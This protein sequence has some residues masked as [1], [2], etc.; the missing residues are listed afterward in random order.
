MKSNVIVTGAAG[1][2]G[3]RLVQALLAR[4]TVAGPSG[5][6]VAFEELRAIDLGRPPGGEGRLATIEGDLSR[7]E[8][9]EAL[10]DAGTLCVFHLAAVVSG[11]AE[12]DFDKGMRVNLD[13]SRLLLEA[14]RHRSRVPTFVFASSVAV[15]G[16][17]LP[18]VVSERVPAAPQT[19]YGVQ[20][21]IVE[22]LVAD[23]CR[24]GYVRGGSLRLPTIVVRPGKPNAALSS[25]ASSIIREPVN[26][27][28]AVC[29][30][31]R[32]A[33]MF[34]LSP[35]RLVQCLLHAESLQGEAYNDRRVVVL[36][37]LSV[38]VSEMLEALA[39]EAGEEVA[40][41]VQFEL[42]PE[43]QRVV[44]GWPLHFDTTLARQMGFAGDTHF[45]EIIRA[46]LEERAAS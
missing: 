18:E 6:E 39:R 22:R 46:F 19:S 23:Y 38:T 11:E 33:G 29:P 32:S 21:A 45:D 37:G 13:A 3:Q 26:G 2:V 16:G 12:R 5:A 36:P 17:D 25:F 34:V 9:V 44:E 42:D 15:Y 20:K 41:R 31:A 43:I 28:R 8:V 30:V 40:A 10:V 4:G 35:R 7:P 27:Q 1:L 14:C 24:K